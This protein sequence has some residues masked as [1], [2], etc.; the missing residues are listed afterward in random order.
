M[1]IEEIV[2]V[3]RR[4]FETP[5]VAGPRVTTLIGDLCEDRFLDTA[6]R[7]GLDSVFHLAATLTIDAERDLATGWAV[8]M[9]LP[10]R[11]LEACRH[12]GR[13]PRFVYASSIAVFGGALPAR[14]S[15]HYVQLPQTSYGTAK[16]ITELL[17]NDYSRHGFVDG[18]A[19]RLPIVVIRPG[20]PTGAISDVIGGLARE[21]LAGADVTCPLSRETRFPVVSVGRVAESLVQLHD[22]PA[23]AFGDS[24]A[25]NQPGLTVTVDDIVAALERV[26]GSDV[27][28]RLR[29]EPVPSVERV[30]SGWPGEF[31][32]EA[33][34]Y[35][36]L[37]P[38]PS[39]E[40]IVRD[41]IR[42]CG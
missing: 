28:A 33:T 7:G 37:E 10:F 25:V 39:F 13:Q 32:T 38:D 6:F 11:L 22:M 29:I 31:V 21:P 8:N 4:P 19:L 40:S 23:A 24:R 41:Y 9:Q 17:I 20:K 15:D 36:S 26:A 14:V 1:P 16:A 27:A 42:S 2:L 12:T 5:A 34:L 3:D 35:P 18:R 30:V